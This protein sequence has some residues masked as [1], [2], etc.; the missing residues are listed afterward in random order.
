MVAMA[1]LK[2][3]EELKESGVAVGKGTQATILELG[4]KEDI[5]R[6]SLVFD[7]EFGLPFRNCFYRGNSGGLKAHVTSP[8]SNPEETLYIDVRYEHDPERSEKYCSP[9]NKGG[10]WHAETNYAIRSTLTV[11]S[12][13]IPEPIALEQITYNQHD[14]SWPWWTGLVPPKAAQE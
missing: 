14:G 9:H 1:M 12:P 11:S 8:Y 7:E 10:K 6:G 4:L 5:L 2:T 3:L 13:K